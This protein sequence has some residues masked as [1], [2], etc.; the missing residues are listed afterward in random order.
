MVFAHGEAVTRHAYSP[1]EEDG[2]GQAAP[3]YTDEVWTGV[4]FAP[5]QSSEP[6][7]NGVETTA[8]LYDPQGRAVSPL[9]EFTVRGERYMVDGDT[10]GQWANPFTGWMPGSVI[11]L[12][13]VSG[14]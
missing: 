14:G 6:L 2:Y 1:G 13:R 10:S 7:R 8:T 11:S 9:D 12:R 5:G 3:T 4:A